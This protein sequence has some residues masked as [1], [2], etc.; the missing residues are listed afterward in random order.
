LPLLEGSA[1]L[2]VV[3]PVGTHTI[4]AMWSA[5]GTSAQLV[6]TVAKASTSIALTLSGG[7]LIATVASV[8]PGAGSPTGTL[9]FLDPASGNLLAT[10]S[11]NA[12]AATAPLPTTT[13]AVVASYSGDA[14]FQ[15]GISQTLSL[16]AVTNAASYATGSV[17]PDELVTVFAPSLPENATVKIVDTLGTAHPAPLVFLAAT[18]ASF[19]IPASLPFGPATLSVTGS[20]RDLST[21]LTVDA[22]APGLFNAAQVITI[23]ADGVRDDPQPATQPI[24]RS[25]PGSKVYLVL[26]GTGLRHMAAAPVCTVGG[27][28][29]SILYAGPQSDI[30][31]LDQVNLELPP[32]LS[33][34]VPVIVII[35]GH[36]ANPLML[37]V[38]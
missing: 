36:P 4:T 26:Y 3:L 1:S 33:G 13:N 9:L 7:S 28:A 27:Q 35:D 30:A 34:S 17:A 29:A 18:Q 19:V 32:L 24:H 6:H 14:N 10:A 8:A 21:P 37:V 22:T 15:G 31:G 20:G 16:L 5:D 12:A 11:L 23:H 2:T 25:E 38:E